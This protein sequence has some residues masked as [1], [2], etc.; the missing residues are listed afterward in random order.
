MTNPGALVPVLMGVG[1]AVLSSKGTSSASAADERTV[2]RASLFTLVIQLV[3]FAMVGFAA[4][5]VGWSLEHDR[6]IERGDLKVEN[7]LIV[8]LALLIVAVA[9]RNAWS[10]LTGS[11]ASCPWDRGLLEVIGEF[12]TFGLALSLIVLLG[13]ALDLFLTFVGASV[14]KPLSTLGL[15]AGLIIVLITA[16]LI[17]QLRT[18]CGPYRSVAMPLREQQRML[19]HLGDAAGSWI[20]INIKPAAVLEPAL[21]FSVSIWAKDGGWYWRPGDAYALS[22][23]HLWAANHAKTPDPALHSQRVSVWAGDLAAS[24]R[25][26]RITNTTRRLWWIDAWRV[27]RDKPQSFVEVGSPEQRAD[28]V[29]IG[30]DEL[31]AAG[32]TATV[33]QAAAIPPAVLHGSSPETVAVHSLARGTHRTTTPGRAAPMG[34]GSP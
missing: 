7:W 11:R 16:A 32:L 4:Y 15:S 9:V 24:R 22:R 5:V 10:G 6:P 8:A 26:M 2:R 30:Y 28:L 25:G 27:H 23:Y 21:S 12:A 19:K 33:E 17:F 3:G 34:R 1:L 14:V 18:L 20:T 29:P 13:L 31:R